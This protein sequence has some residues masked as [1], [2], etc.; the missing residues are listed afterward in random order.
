MGIWFQW[1]LNRRPIRWRWSDKWRLWKNRRWWQEIL[2][3]SNR[4]QLFTKYR[5]Q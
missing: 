3:S 5:R 4:H 1:N 2:D